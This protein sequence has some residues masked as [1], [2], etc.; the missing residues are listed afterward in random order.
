MNLEE[1]IEGSSPLARGTLRTFFFRPC[2]RG[3]IPARAGNTRAYALGKED[4]RAHPRSR[5]EHIGT[6]AAACRDWGSSPL[7]RGTLKVTNEVATGRGLIPARAGNTRS[8]SRRATALWAHPRS[9]GEHVKERMNATAESG[10][11]PLA[12]GTRGFP[13]AVIQLSGLIPARAGNT[14]AFFLVALVC[15]GSSPLARGTHAA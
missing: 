5:G 12:R 7:A 4:R 3:L 9:R 8:I 13:F 1:F 14:E 2:N 11:S 6:G 15:G 10:S